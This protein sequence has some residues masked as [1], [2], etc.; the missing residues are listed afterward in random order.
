[1]DKNKIIG[2]LKSICFKTKKISPQDFQN[3]YLK[4]WTR[5]RISV[6]LEKDEALIFNEIVKEIF[7]DPVLYQNFSVADI[8]KKLQEIIS[9]VLKEQVNKREEKIKNE[10]DIFLQSLNSKIKEWV[11][12]FPIENLNLPIR[13]LKL[14]DIIFYRFTN[15]RANKYLKIIR[16]NLDQNPYYQ[17]N[18]QFIDQFVNQ[19]KAYNVSPLIDKICAE[20]KTKGTLDGA[21][22]RALRKLDFILSFIKL[23]TPV[24]DSSAKS[25]FGLLGEIIPPN[26][27][28]I[29]SYKSDKTEFHPRIERTGYLY[30]YEIDKEK[31]KTMRQYGL[32]TLLNIEKKNNRTDLETRILNS[33]LW[34]SKAFDIPIFR[35]PEGTK[36][37]S[38]DSFVS[39]E[40]EY[41]SLGDKFLKLIVALESLLIFG[42]ENKR[43]NISRRSSYIITDSHENRVEIQ[44]YLKKTYDIRS[45]IVHEGGYVVS[46]AETLKLMLYV[47]HVIIS[48][49]CF[50]NKWKI[51]TNEDFYQWLEKNRLRDRLIE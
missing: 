33:I 31:T 50:K 38:N 29:L 11:F 4:I 43:D 24:G 25:Y 15:Y 17:N 37:Q 44:K 20:I 42:R 13:Q 9:K 36:L 34:Y 16:N 51:N 46:Q 30:P 8:E 35:K 40:T 5:D 3:K 10:I 12:I 18:R 32:R 28:S 41:F 21:R 14:N 23:F 49:I 22:Q 6:F 2:K 48:F 39:E 47:Q 7:S 26:R 27:R 45:R 1:M 19:I